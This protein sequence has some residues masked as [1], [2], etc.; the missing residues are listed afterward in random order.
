MQTGSFSREWH[1]LKFE[2]SYMG[3]EMKDGLRS[4]NVL[5]MLK[6]WYETGQKAIVDLLQITYIDF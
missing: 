4:R 3:F 2:L 5:E 6:Y 1:G